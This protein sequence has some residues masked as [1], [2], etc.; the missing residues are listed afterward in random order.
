M[1]PAIETTVITI[2]SVGIFIYK[3]TKNYPTMCER[4]ISL[5]A[6]QFLEG[7][8]FWCEEGFY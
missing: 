8:V 3:S 1:K 4:L 7:G 2:A 5:K 6:Y